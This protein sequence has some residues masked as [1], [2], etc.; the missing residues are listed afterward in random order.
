[1]LYLIITTLPKLMLLQ[2]EA[3]ILSHQCHWNGAD[4]YLWRLLSL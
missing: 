4:L 2:F 1:M 3:V